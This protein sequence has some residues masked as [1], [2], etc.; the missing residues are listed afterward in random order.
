MAGLLVALVACDSLVTSPPRYAMVD[1]LTTRRDGTPVAHVPVVLSTGQ[2]IIGYDTTNANGTA[3]FVRVPEGPA[4]GVL[5]GVPEGYER[6]EKL[7]GGSVT[8][9]VP[10][11]LTRDSTPLVRFQFLKVG[12]GTVTAKVVDQAAAPLAGVDVE[13]FG[14]VSV[15]ARKATAA[16]GRVT[17]SAVPF[18]GYGVRAFRPAAYRDDGE[19]VTLDVD[20]LIIEEGVT[21]TRTLALQR[22]VGSVSLQVSDAA[23]GAA[24]NVRAQLFN[25]AGVAD[26][27]KTG[28]NG[29]VQFTNLDCD[30]YGVR[31]LPAADWVV[32][33]GRGSDFVDGLILHR[34]T[35]LNAALP[36]QYNTC[37][38]SVRVTVADAAGNAVSGASV[39]VTTSYDDPVVTQTT[40]NA[41]V[42]FANLGC[43]PE[44]TVAITAPSGWVAT[45]GRGGSYLDGLLVTNGGQLDVRF[46]LGRTGR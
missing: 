34:G 23:R 8:D 36:V 40:S 22:C 38:G 16:D 5:A 2:R 45:P 10:F 30:G 44:R 17:F 25:A 28:A 42:T 14:S 41:P 15:I 20:G 19:A 1:V 43:G 46:T 4:Y 6:L 26:A 31:I 9:F 11:A 3:R 33:P 39:L 35:A 27:K 37:R 12:P 13:L 21:E 29:T 24:A 18:G 7:L 32:T